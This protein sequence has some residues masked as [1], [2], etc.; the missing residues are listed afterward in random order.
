MA[1][2][3]FRLDH[4]QLR[5]VVDVMGIY[6]EDAPRGELGSMLHSIVLRLRGRLEK[7]LPERRLEYQLVL[8]VHDALA[9]RRMCLGALEWGV[10]ERRATELR[11]IL[12]IIDPRVAQHL[13]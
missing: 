3:R 2:V 8:P 12:G 1:E 11:I 6:L 9:L 4:D 13:L 7:R 5:I 10:P